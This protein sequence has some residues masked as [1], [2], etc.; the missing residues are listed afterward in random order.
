MPFRPDN[1][2]EALFRLRLEPK[3][4]AGDLGEAD[5]LGGV[6]KDD[7]AL[8]VLYGLLFDG[9]ITRSTPV[10]YRLRPRKRAAIDDASA[11]IK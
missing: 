6:V 8:R 1:L 4:D 11:E 3:P 10:E 7:D 2:A 9:A 5:F